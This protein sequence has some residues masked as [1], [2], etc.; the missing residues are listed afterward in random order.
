MENDLSDN[1]RRTICRVLFLFVCA[2]PT[3]A[4]A[5]FATHQRTADQWAQ[6][7]QAELGVKTSI[8]SVETPLPGEFVFQ[9]LK[10]FDNNGT[11]IFESLKTHVSMGIKNRID[12]YNRTPVTR[13]GMSYF[14]KESAGR[15]V[16]PLPGSPAPWEIVFHDIQINDP[17]A[18]E[19]DVR[20]IHSNRLDVELRN[21]GHGTIVDG[22][23]QRMGHAEA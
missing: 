17:G 18:S 11:P 21:G 3:I 22:S 16:K 13:A 9:D 12:F 2:L 7:L 14:L 23:N 20:S 4:V 10:L 8:G 6:L 5:Y 1:Q 19:Y 15:L